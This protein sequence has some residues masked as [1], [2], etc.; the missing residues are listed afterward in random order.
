MFNLKE[1]VITNY[2]CKKNVVQ[3]KVK[4]FPWYVEEQQYKV[5]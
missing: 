2:C 1:F 3:F 5:L 4:C